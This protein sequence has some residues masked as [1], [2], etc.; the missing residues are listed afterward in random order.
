L[1]LGGESPEDRP[2]GGGGTFFPVSSWFPAFVLTLA[3]EAPIVLA[4]VRP[5]RSEL[6][7]FVVLVLFA[8]LATH[9]AVWFVL[10]QL[11]LL[12]TPEYLLVAES[13][14]I[15]AEAVFYLAAF[16]GLTAGRAATLALVANLASALVGRLVATEVG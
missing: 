1:R 11:F 5:P 3:V 16:R 9:L 4:F 13:W 6:P 15:A 10:T 14:A 8:N 7:R 12:G 2:V